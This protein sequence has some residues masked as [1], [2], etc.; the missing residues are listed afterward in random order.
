MLS[1][2]AKAANPA[3]KH[4][5]LSPNHNVRSKKLLAALPSATDTLLNADIRIPVPVMLVDKDADDSTDDVESLAEERVF[6]DLS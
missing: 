6:A 1:I 3:L 5:I 2:Q 4:L